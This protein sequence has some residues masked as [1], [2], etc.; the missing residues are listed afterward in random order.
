LASA[1]REPVGTFAGLVSSTGNDFSSVMIEENVM[2][3]AGAVFHLWADG[4][5]RQI[6]AAGFLHRRRNMRYQHLSGNYPSQELCTVCSAMC[7][8]TACAI[9][10]S[11]ADA[12]RS[13]CSPGTVTAGISPA[14]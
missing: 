2:A 13:V 7:A 10:D 3:Q 14:T 11:L 5:E 4:I 8:E 6:R 9:R 12:K 1:L